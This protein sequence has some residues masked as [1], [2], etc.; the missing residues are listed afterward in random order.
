M[1]DFFSVEVQSLLTGLLDR[2]PKKRI[3]KATDIKKH[4]WFKR[5]DWKLLWDK[6]LKAPF[7]PTVSSPDDTRNIDVMFLKET[8]KETMP[9]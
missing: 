2:D 1:Y 4:P 3:S 9:M 5:I 6:K 7:K 8:I